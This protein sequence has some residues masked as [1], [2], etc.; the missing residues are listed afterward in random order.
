MKFKA[1][2]SA[3]ALAAAGVAHADI[4]ISA[5]NGPAEAFVTVFNSKASITIDLGLDQDTFATNLASPLSFNLS[6]N[7]NWA[8]FISASA[9]GTAL[10]WSVQ[11]LDGDINNGWTTA[12]VGLESKAGTTTGGARQNGNLD[13]NFADLTALFINNVNTDG[14]IA[15]NAS[16]VA[17][18]GTN[19]YW[20]PF[21]GANSALGFVK[22]SNVINSTAVSLFQFQDKVSDPFNAVAN[23]DWSKS[24]DTVTLNSNYVLTFQGAAVTPSVP[25]P[26]SYGL[27]LVALAAI[28]FV[29]RRRSI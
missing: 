15:T 1:L 21:D 11:S 6:S 19:Q 14:V 29:A 28:G 16:T 10:L 20:G 3:V 4:N 27:A 12:R 13:S 8:S 26:E 24:T 5:S 7:A 2:V 17:V 23:Y 25:E 9:G 22:T 18:A